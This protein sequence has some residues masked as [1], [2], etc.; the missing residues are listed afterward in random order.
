MV[1]V[2]IRVFIR[3]S[4]YNSR[5]KT[6]PFDRDEGLSRTLQ[7]WKVAGTLPPRFQEE[8]WRRIERAQPSPALPF[9]KS[10]WG[11]IDSTLHAPR[12]ACVYLAVLLLLGG[13]FG[14]WQ[15]TQEQ[16]RFDRTMAV[17]YV[18]S[19]DPYHMDMGQR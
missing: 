5:M 10:L 17:R 8:V 2:F 18:A 14:L 15:G 7:E 12:F 19:V 13:G 16:D 9:W 3:I 11:L 1:R 6:N 4:A